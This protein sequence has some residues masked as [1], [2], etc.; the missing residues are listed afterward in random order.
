MRLILP[1]RTVTHL[2]D[3]VAESSHSALTQAGKPVS[4]SLPVITSQIAEYVG[5]TDATHCGTEAPA[6]KQPPPTQKG[7]L[8]PS[9]STLAKSRLAAALYIQPHADRRR[10]Q[11][12]PHAM[13]CQLQ[14]GDQL[15]Q[16][17]TRS[18]GAGGLMVDVP[19]APALSRG[20]HALVWLDDVGPA[21]VRICN[22]TQEG[23]HLAFLGKRSPSL[24]AVLHGL[25]LRLETE[26]VFATAHVRELAMVIEE[27]FERGLQSGHV[28]L[29]ALMSARYT[30]IPGTEP[31]QFLHPALGFYEDVLPAVQQPY[32]RPGAGMLYALATDRNGYVP[33]HNNEYCKPQRP[34]DLAYNLVH[35]RNRRLFDD[36][37]TIV[38][39]RLANQPVVQT[40]L[41][42]TGEGRSALVRSIGVPIFVRGRRWGCAQVAYQMEDKEPPSGKT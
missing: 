2:L 20:Q 31:Q 30:L 12:Y 25:L 7:A 41:R 35:S 14:I 32:L 5:R 22:L 21:K 34:G 26:N 1:S 8:Q 6:K 28:D 37:S 19:N 33:V 36:T 15:L 16:L 9:I 38:A 17:R 13:P 18:I 24:R 42:D 4:A 3:V 11:R 27:T 29:Q 39:A 40:Y 10:L 23:L